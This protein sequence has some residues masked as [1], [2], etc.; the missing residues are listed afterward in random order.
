MN[1]KIAMTSCLLLLSSTTFAQD[2]N[3]YP[4]PV[5]ECNGCNELEKEQAVSKLAKL[6]EIVTVALVDAYEGKAFR[7]DVEKYIDKHGVTQGEGIKFI[8]VLTP[9][10]VAPS[11]SE[12]AKQLRE[13]LIES[14][15]LNSE[16]RKEWLRKEAQKP[17]KPGQSKIFI[18]EEK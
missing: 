2:I 15:N 18:L 6:D 13:M 9:V 8:T 5:I 14:W 12:G 11:L 16:E 1:L 4:Y 17:L 10:P 7:Y 3:P